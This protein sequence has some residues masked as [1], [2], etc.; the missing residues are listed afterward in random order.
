MLLHSIFTTSP[1]IWNMQY[2]RLLIP[3][4]SDILASYKF[5]IKLMVVATQKA[6]LIAFLRQILVG[7]HVAHDLKLLSIF[8]LKSGII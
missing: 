5:H 2:M 3:H 4:V 7:I 6:C 1:E 8:Y